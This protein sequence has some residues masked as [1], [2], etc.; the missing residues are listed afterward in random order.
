MPL[1]PKLAATMLVAATVATLS[2]LSTPAYADDPLPPP[3]TGGG[4][5]AQELAEDA[6]RPVLSA[7]AC[8]DDPLPPPPTGGGSNV[9]ELLKYVYGTVFDCYYVDLKRTP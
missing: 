3:P 9:Q 7:P 6:P 5:H 4:R 1:A 2:V 8:A